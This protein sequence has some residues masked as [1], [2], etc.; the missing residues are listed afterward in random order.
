MPTLSGALCAIAGERSGEATASVAVPAAPESNARRVIGLMILVLDIGGAPS[1]FLFYGDRLRD[2]G[3]RPQLGRAG[4]PSKPAPPRHIMHHNS[5]RLRFA[6]IIMQVDRVIGH[7]HC[8]DS[9]PSD[10]T[11]APHFARSA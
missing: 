4:F 5:R 2:R 3:R 10:L 7:S 11:T 6:R 8:E 1:A 9:N